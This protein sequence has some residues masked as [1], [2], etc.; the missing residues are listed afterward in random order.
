MSMPP[1][2]TS[3]HIDKIRL[4]TYLAKI[5]Q[6]RCCYCG[7]RMIVPKR[8][9]ARE[10][11]PSHMLTI[12]H[13]LSKGQPNRNH[14]DHC[15]A[16]CILCNSTRGIRSPIEHFF[17]IQSMIFAGTYRGIVHPDYI[18]HVFKLDTEDNANDVQTRGP[19]EDEL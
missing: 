13:L 9:R 4:R 10:T 2:K 6:Y 5:Q 18:R 11:Q 8:K 3:I 19:S 12:E 14:A 7:V 17:H 1:S 16:A 15:V